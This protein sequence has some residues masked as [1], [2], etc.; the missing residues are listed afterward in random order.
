MKMYVLIPILLNMFFVAQMPAEDGM[1]DPYQIMA[2]HYEAVG[3]LDRLKAI[4]TIFARGEFSIVGSDLK[5]TVKSWEE[6]PLRMRME[7]DLGVVQLVFGD[8]GEKNWHIDVNKK[9]LV[10]EDE[11]MIKERKIK[12]LMADFAHLDP[13]SPVFD[14]SFEG[15][16]KVNNEDCYVVK[17]AN[18]I[19]ENIEYHYY[20]KK[21]YYLVKKIEVK[22]DREDHTEYADFRSIDGVIQPFH[23]ISKNLS[24]GE[25]QEIDYTE[26]LI[27]PE[28]AADIFEI[29][30]DDAEDFMFTQGTSAQDIPFKLIENSIYLPV[31]INGREKLW[32]LDC[33]ASVTVIDSSYA[34]ELGLEFQ[35]PMKAQAVSGIV[36]LY[37]VTIPA[38]SMKGITFNEQ[39]V[40][41]MNISSLF[42]K[43]LGMEI[44]GI[45]GYDF[46]S[47]FITKIDYA[48]E[49]IS[50]YEP[51]TYE[52]QGKGKII[53]SPLGEERMFS[54]DAIVD[55][56]YSGKWQL[57]IGATGVDFHYPYAKEHGLLE[58]DGVEG[59]YFGAAGSGKAKQTCFKTMELAGLG[60]KDV[61]IGIPQQISRGAF[62]DKSLIGNMG[63]SFL[64]HFVLFL[65]YYN[66]RVILEKGDDYA[67]EFP[68]RKSGMGVWYNDDKQVE[69]FFIASNTPAHEAGIEKGDVIITV[70]GIKTEYLDGL[71]ALRRL[72]KEKAGTKLVFGIIRN[73]DYLEKTMILRD[74]YKK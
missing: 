7:I 16:E 34:A 50:F 35:G 33:G 54:L 32:V 74:L 51:E 56:K 22:P 69:V 17:I 6:K 11:A 1:E 67:R 26:Y 5:G 21:S 19:N 3:G 49:K 24:T 41:T 39:K 38:Y 57:D 13:D 18:K 52:Y 70:N 9:I 10:R 72:F 63:N 53:D 60:V 68:E 20:D 15:V 45:L 59:M 31:N 25:I 29:P 14:I 2:R 44:A 8:D 36:D 61:L 27:N 47:R 62:T 64:R 23:E 43:V 58:L 40:M 12:E 66:Q 65:D 46:L 4:K 37:F 28:I 30:Q 42:N 73:G 71:I 55:K 48:N